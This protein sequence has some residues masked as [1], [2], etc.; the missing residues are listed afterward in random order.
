MH[1]HNKN[2]SI[3]LICMLEYFPYVSRKIKSVKGYI[4]IST[5]TRKIMSLNDSRKMRSKL[6]DT[7]VYMPIHYDKP[8]DVLKELQ[9]IYNLTKTDAKE[10]IAQQQ[11]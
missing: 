9:E 5:S 4:Y 3:F 8:N 2:T 7:K 11:N 10:Q 6:T 1:V